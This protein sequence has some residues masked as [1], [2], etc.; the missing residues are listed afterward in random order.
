MECGC[1]MLRS[2]RVSLHQCQ[3]CN[4]IQKHTAAKFKLK[5]NV[6][7][8]EEEDSPENVHSVLFYVIKRHSA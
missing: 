5:K 6:C 1:H 8:F 7:G 2:F 4:E 3:M